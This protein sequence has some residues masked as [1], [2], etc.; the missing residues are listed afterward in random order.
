MRKQL[1]YLLEG[2]DFYDGAHVVEE[3]K[4][5]GGIEQ[6]TRQFFHGNQDDEW[7]A[8]R[9][10]GDDDGGDNKNNNSKGPDPLPNTPR[11]KITREGTPHSD[12]FALN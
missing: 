8:M 9:V 7:V 3:R 5:E 12:L 6:V 4:V 2:T 1:P 10:D 11:D